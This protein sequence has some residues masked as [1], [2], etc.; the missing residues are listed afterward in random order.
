MAKL[1]QVGAAILIKKKGALASTAS[2][3]KI[4][5]HREDGSPDYA[6]GAQIIWMTD[7]K[8]LLNGE[9]RY[10]PAY[11][12]PASML[13]NPSTVETPKPVAASAPATTLESKVKGA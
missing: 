12:S 13:P 3:I 9:I 5:P 8:Y 10:A 6:Q 7:V 11:F 1:V 2:G 4:F